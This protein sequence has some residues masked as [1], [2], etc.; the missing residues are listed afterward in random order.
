MYSAVSY[1]LLHGV[2]FQVT[3]AAVHL[4]RPVADLRGDNEAA[5]MKTDQLRLQVRTHVK[6]LVRGEE[7]GHGAEGDGVR[8]ALLQRLRRL[9]HQQAGRHQPRGHFCQFELEKLQRGQQR[10]RS[11]LTWGLNAPAGLAWL[12]D[13]VSP[14]C[15]RT[16]RWSL[17]SCTQACAAPRE[18]EAV[19]G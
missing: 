16:S 3:V 4:E 7:L 9:A 18:Q 2:V 5:W 1:K 12:L 6:A 15:F 14:N 19:G 11:G 8:A 17:A 13:S 10:V